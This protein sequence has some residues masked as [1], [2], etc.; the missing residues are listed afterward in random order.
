MHIC[1]ERA[2]PAWA[3]EPGDAALSPGHGRLRGP[4][5]RPRP[6][7][8]AACGVACT[9]ARR[10]AVAVRSV[11]SLKV[12][13]SDHHSV[14]S[15]QPLPG[16]LIFTVIMLFMTESFGIHVDVICNSIVI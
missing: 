1:A 5:A 3:A 4:R 15:A 10:V 16:P 6:G 7:L 13:R 9:Q 11:Y 12:T 14:I 2:E 8:P